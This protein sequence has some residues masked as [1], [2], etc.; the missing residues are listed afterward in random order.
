[1][2][3]VFKSSSLLF[4]LLFI[5]SNLFSQQ[6]CNCCSAYHDDFDFWIGTWEVFDTNENKV[7]ENTIRKIEKGCALQE[8]WTG[9]SGVTGQSTNYF[10]PA[11]STWNQIWVSSTG[12]VLNLKGG[13]RDNAMVMRSSM[14]H[15]DSTIY[16]HEIKW[17]KSED[18]HDVIQ[19][20]TT[21]DKDGEIIKLLFKGIYQR[22]IKEPID[23]R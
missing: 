2:A 12:T 7:G 14:I 1:M 21:R 3:Q 5:T 20:W 22:E 17:S 10:D 18:S 4:I 23:F 8:N 9:V 16:Y 13:L 19:E 11:D 6:G 15:T